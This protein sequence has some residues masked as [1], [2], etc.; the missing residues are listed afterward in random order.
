M[1]KSLNEQVYENLLEK[2]V[3]TEP[4]APESIYEGVLDDDYL[5]VYNN[6]LQSLTTDDIPQDFVE[7]HYDEIEEMCVSPDDDYHPEEYITMED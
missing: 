6:W 1:V 4:E 3:E 5:E 2:Y 7:E